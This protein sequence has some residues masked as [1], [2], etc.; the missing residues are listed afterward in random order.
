M[1]V[2][3]GRNVNGVYAELVRLVRREGVKGESRGGDVLV[4]PAPVMLGTHRPQE[5]VLLDVGRDANPFFHLFES[6]FLLAGRDDYTWLD[7]FVRNFSSSFAEKDGHGH[8]SY[9]RRWRSHFGFDQLDEVVRKLRA[10]QNDRRVVISMWD[11]TTMVYSYGGSDDKGANDLLAEARDVPCNTHIYPRIVN[12]ALDLTVCCRSNDAIWGA[13]GANAVQ[14]SILLE[15]LSGRIGVQT[16][17]LYQLANNMHAYTA[18][19]GR[20][21]SPA[22]TKF[23]ADPYEGLNPTPIG[24][25][26]EHWDEDLRRFMEFTEGQELFDYSN[27]WW[28]EV[29]HPMW[30]AHKLFSEGKKDFALDAVKTVA[31]PDWRQACEAWIRR[32]M[33]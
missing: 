6:L 31:A 7:R 22:M 3:E 5:R 28:W 23:S 33:K 16:G 26:W 13:T 15:Y 32:R 17:K 10:D 14:F 25:D 2:I 27:T 4:L 9:G 18:R 24:V 21:G 29:V 12:G 11:P 8:G 30:D 20:Y 19:L 1:Y